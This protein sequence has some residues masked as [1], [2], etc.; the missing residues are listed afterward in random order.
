MH[1]RYAKAVA[2][3]DLGLASR[4]YRNAI[5]A[6]RLITICFRRGTRFL[7]NGGGNGLFV[8]LMRASG[9]NGCSR[10]PWTS[11]R[12]THTRIEPPTSRS[13]RFE[14]VEHTPKIELVEVVIVKD[15]RVPEIG[16][17]TMSRASTEGGCLHFL[18]LAAR[19]TSRD[20]PDARQ[21]DPDWFEEYD[22]NPATDMGEGGPTPADAQGNPG[23]WLASLRDL[24]FTCNHP[25][26]VASRYCPGRRSGAGHRAA[27]F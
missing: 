12:N 19:S 6:A 15:P 9:H 25:G 11:D 5:I 27:T 1:G 24:D 10:E 22:Q 26:K 13:R 7:D 2:P 14:C 8:R 23:D 3:T 17:E 18:R 4:C 16:G 20:G 21:P